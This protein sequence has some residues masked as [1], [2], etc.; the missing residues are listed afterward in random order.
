MLKCKTHYHISLTHMVSAKKELNIN[1]FYNNRIWVSDEKKCFIDKI[2]YDQWHL[3]LFIAVDI[4]ATLN[5]DNG[6]LRSINYPRIKKYSHYK[7]IYSFVDLLE[8]NV[9]KTVLKN[10]YKYF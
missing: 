2:T 5:S 6:R 9:C 7:N 1:V 4:V 8:N 3:T 10:R